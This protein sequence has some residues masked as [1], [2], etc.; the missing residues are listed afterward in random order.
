MIGIYDVIKRPIVTE[1]TMGQLDRSNTY[2]FEVHRKATK[3]QIRNAVEKL[4]NVQVA[5]V[6]TA[7]VKGKPIRRGRW[8]G[9]SPNWKKAFVTLRGEDAIELF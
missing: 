4:F 8:V 1:S 2:V 3:V 9:H 7:R 6:N 5:K